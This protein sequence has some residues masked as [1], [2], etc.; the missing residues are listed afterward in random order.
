MNT[1]IAL[2]R[3]INVLGRNSVKME[4]LRALHERLG[5]KKV[6][7]YIQSGNIILSAH[8]LAENITRKMSEEFA[9]E[10]GFSAKIALVDTKRWGAIVERN[11][12]ANFAAD[13]HKSVHAGICVGEPS[14]TGLKA[15]LAKTGGSETFAI[16]DGVV[17]LHTPDGFGRSKFAAGMEKACGV[18]MTLRNWRTMESL[19]NMTLPV[20]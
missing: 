1:Y 11:P 6:Q 3:G 12:Y 8:G 20:E 16:R 2:Y 15:L 17:Y 10:F 13:N 7:S 5:H 18:A 9:R 4:S 19:W 14:A